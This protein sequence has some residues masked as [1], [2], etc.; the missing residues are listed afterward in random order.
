MQ[1]A[2]IDIGVAP[3][4]QGKSVFLNALNFAFVFQPGLT[5]LPYLSIIDIG[6]SSSGL[7]NLVKSCLPDDLKYLAVYKRLKNTREFAVNPFDT[8]LGV[9][10]PLPAHKAF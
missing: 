6:L 2:W 4:G 1:S 8:P 7:I 5:E 3:M 9:Y 10:K